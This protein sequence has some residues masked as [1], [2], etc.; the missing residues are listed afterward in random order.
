MIEVE[1]PLRHTK[2]TKT[3]KKQLHRSYSDTICG[4]D[5]PMVYTLQTQAFRN[6]KWFLD[7]EPALVTSGYMISA[8]NEVLTDFARVL[9]RVRGLRSK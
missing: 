2:T 6:F 4:A 1:F 3:S 8:S 9:R 5:T 7:N